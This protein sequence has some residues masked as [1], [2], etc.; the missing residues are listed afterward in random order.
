MLTSLEIKILGVCGSPIKGGNTQVFLEQALKAAEETGGVKTELILLAGKNIHDCRHCNWCMI[1]QEEG[2]YCNVQDDMAELFPRLI[3]SDAIMIATPVYMTRPT[4]YLSCF[5][6][7][8]RC[9]G[10]GKFYKQMFENKI[11]GALAVA[12]YRHQGMETALQAIVSSFMLTGMLP[13]NCGGFG[14]GS[15]YG[16]CGVTSPGGEGKFDSKVKLGVLQDEYGLFSARSLG[17][18]LAEVTKIVKRG[19]AYPASY[20]KEL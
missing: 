11:G 18:K 15:P 20:S 12:W 9:I 17:K 1:R 5:L 13:V 3:E 4:G 10:H 8:W 16:A 7:R 19:R 2:K 14:I 6:D